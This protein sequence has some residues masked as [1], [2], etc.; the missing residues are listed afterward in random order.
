MVKTDGTAAGARGRAQRAGVRRDRRPAA[1]ARLATRS[2]TRSF[3]AEVLLVGDRVVVIATGC[4]PRRPGGRERGSAGP[5]PRRRRVASR[6]RRL[7]PRPAD[8]GRRTGPTT[9]RCSPPGSTATWSGWCSQAGLP[10]LDFVTPLEGTDEDIA[11][12]ARNRALVRASTIEDWLP[13]VGTGTARPGRARSAGRLRRG[14]DPRRRRGRRHDRGRRLR[15]CDAPDA[16]G[17]PWPSTA[18]WRHGLLLGRPALPRDHGRTRPSLL[19]PAG[20]PVRRRAAPSPSSA[21]TYHD[22]FDLDR[23]R[24]RRTPRVGQVDGVIAD[25]WSMD[26]HDGVHRCPGRGRHRRRRDRQLQLVVTLRQEG[27][28]P[29][30][31]PAASTGSASASRSSRCAG[32]T[33]SRSW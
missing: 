18:G 17:R 21:P 16:R 23:Y 15:R 28:R 8:P 29:G 22:A 24:A 11:R 10:D 19:P 3:D 1:G 7:R 32:S 5:G 14:R 31:G 6:A 20:L 27:E 33:T 12:S 2:R 30:R 25:R 4:A 9:A 26:E 13:T